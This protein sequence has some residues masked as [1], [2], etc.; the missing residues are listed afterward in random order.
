[1]RV[2]CI[3]YFIAYSGLQH[4]S[5]SWLL[6]VLIYKC[7]DSV[8]RINFR[9]V[10]VITVFVGKPLTG[11]MTISREDLDLFNLLSIV[12]NTALLS[13]EFPRIKS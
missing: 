8:L 3:F 12:L 11:L 13:V 2:T 10:S 1:M 5:N 9:P 7:D 6:L 4:S